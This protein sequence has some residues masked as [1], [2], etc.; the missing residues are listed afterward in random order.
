M[1]AAAVLIAL[2]GIVPLPAALVVAGVTGLAVGV[3]SIGAFGRA[4]PRSV[5]AES[6]ILGSVL[7]AGAAGAIRLV[8]TGLGWVPVLLLAG[9]GLRAVLRLEGR[10]V[11]ATASPSDDDRL[12]LLAGTIG[13]SFVAFTG[14]AALVPGALVDPGAA[15]PISPLPSVHGPSISAP[16][17][18]ASTG[19]TSRGPSARTSRRAASGWSTTTSSTST[20]R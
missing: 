7:A 1:L 5:P 16:R 15:Q 9:L 10:L 2:T 19:P 12:R 20:T 4:D 3:A 6:I 8:P 14:V 11:G 18:I 13:I 17:S